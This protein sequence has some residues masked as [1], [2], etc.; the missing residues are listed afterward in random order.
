MN[1]G[2]IK[3]IEEVYD[4]KSS[5]IGNLIGNNGSQLGISGMLNAIMGWQSF[6][7]YMVET[8]HKKFYILIE[9]GQSC[10]EN[11]GYLSTNDDINY[12]IG[13]EIS[14]ISLTDDNLHN[15]DLDDLNYLDDGGVVFVTFYMVDGD[16]LQLAVYNCHNG[17]YGHSILIVED[18]KILL[19]DCL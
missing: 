11:W 10:C 7:G 17:Y 9:N 4:L 6:D 12:F 3:K 2:K 5:N 14:R 16:T 8:E 15:K 13:K 18:D 19:E 1:I